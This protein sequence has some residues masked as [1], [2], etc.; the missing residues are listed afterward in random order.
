MTPSSNA[1]A[2]KATNREVVDAGA[3]TASETTVP[4]VLISL[5]GTSWFRAATVWRSF[6]AICESSEAV[7][8]AMVMSEGTLRS[9][10]VAVELYGTYADPWIQLGLFVWRS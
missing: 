7:R 9:S 6:V 2:P 4:M 1:T 8:M 10:R 5:T 3:D